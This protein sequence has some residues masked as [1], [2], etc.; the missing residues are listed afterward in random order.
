MN[1]HEAARIE[2][3]KKYFD[4]RPGAFKARAAEVPPEMSAPTSGPRSSLLPGEGGF[5]PGS[6]G[7]LALSFRRLSVGFLFIF[8]GAALVN[9]GIQEQRDCDARGI[10]CPIS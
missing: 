9:S 8:T 4:G 3:P 1:F 6:P 10:Q 2:V 5:A 7:G